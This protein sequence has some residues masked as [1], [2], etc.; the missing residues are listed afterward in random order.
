MTAPADQSARAA[1]ARQ[2]LDAAEACFERFGIA[3]TTME[4]V[5]KAGG[6]SR[7]TVYRYFADR[8]ALVLASVTRRARQNIPRAHAHIATFPTFAEKLVEGLVYNIDRGRRD[9]VVQLL[10]TGDQPGL[11]ARVLGGEGVSHELSHELWQPVLAAAQE[12]GEMAAPLDLRSCSSW[13]A[14]VTLMMVAQEETVRLAPDA[15]RRE[16][17]TFVVPAFLPR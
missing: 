14:R 11:A 6:V 5:A 1:V 8:E 3:K 7:A 2:L 9:P 12:A 4:D 17:R 15:L 10:V 16:M 13:L